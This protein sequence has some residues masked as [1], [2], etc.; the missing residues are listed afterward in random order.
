MYGCVQAG[1]AS[2]ADELGRRILQSSAVSGA[3]SG[4]RAGAVEDASDA[5]RKSR[6]ASAPKSIMV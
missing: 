1:K 6:A 4:G 2:E 5:P 3:V